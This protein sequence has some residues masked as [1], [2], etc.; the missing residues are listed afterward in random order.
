MD[1]K[2]LRN[3]MD[4]ALYFFNNEKALITG[5][6]GQ[7]GAYLAISYKKKIKV[8]GIVRRTSFDPLTRLEYFNIKNKS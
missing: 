3:K 2:K 4:H 1:H 7:D 6:T 5:I 8:Y